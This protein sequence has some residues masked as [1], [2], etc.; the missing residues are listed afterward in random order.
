MGSVHFSIDLKLATLLQRELDLNTFVETG[1]FRGETIERMRPLF[2]RLH[3]VEYSEE[4]YTDARQKFQD[5]E[6]IELVQGD[7]PAFL[8][9][10]ADEFQTQPVMFW[11]DAHWCNAA[12]VDGEKSQCPLL[13]ELAAI[14]KLHPSSVVWIDD[15]RFFLCSPPLNHHVEDW[16]RLPEVIRGLDALSDRHEYRVINDTIVFFPAEKQKLIDDFAAEEGIDW[17]NL[18]NHARKTGFFD[19]T[20]PRKKNFRKKYLSKPF[21]AARDAVTQCWRRMTSSESSRNKLRTPVSR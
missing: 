15:A 17:L 4:L 18:M 2:D 7:S 1:T 21:R 14:G 8:R 16:P 12:G 3:T 13:E 5:L 20:Q 19:P 11:L 6:E 9:D 10:R